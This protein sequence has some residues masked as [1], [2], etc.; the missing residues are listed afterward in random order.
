M[1]LDL[2]RLTGIDANSGVEV[3]DPDSGEVFD[4]DTAPTPVLAAVI[5]RYD[6]AIRDALDELRAIK[7]T[8]GD[9]LIERMDRQGEWTVGARG[10][11]VSAP[12]P[13][14]GVISYDAE[15]L[16]EVLDELVAKGVIDASAKLRAVT[17]KVTLETHA[18]G[19]NALLKIPG[20]AKYVENCRVE[21]V[22]PAR[23]VTV[24]VNAG[25]M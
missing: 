17:Q 21:Q 9:E 3:I 19:I 14:A 22:P 25:E 10:V 23:K 6:L 12:S 4:L 15:K 13:A 8:L 5:G 2:I 7:R 24:K 11:K 20:A 16:D 1:A 18:S